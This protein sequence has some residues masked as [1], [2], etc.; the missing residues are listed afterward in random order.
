[1]S[2]VNSLV[3]SNISG[4]IEYTAKETINPL[5]DDAQDSA[6]RERSDDG[7]VVRGD[8]AV[9]SVLPVLSTILPVLRPV[10]P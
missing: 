2:I 6:E 7:T 3:D 5:G 4:E 9:L 1:M 10:L 8:P